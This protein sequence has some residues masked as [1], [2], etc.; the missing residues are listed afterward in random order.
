[1]WTKYIH[2]GIDEMCSRMF[3]GLAKDWGLAE[4]LE[5]PEKWSFIDYQKI[6]E[7]FKGVS[8][9]SC[10][11]SGGRGVQSGEGLTSERLGLASQWTGGPGT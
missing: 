9:T 8:E 11:R 4:F 3:L 7:L 10:A 2:R 1:M 5:Y 6:I